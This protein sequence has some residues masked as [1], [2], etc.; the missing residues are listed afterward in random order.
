MADKGEDF[1]NDCEVCGEPDT[2]ICGHWSLEKPPRMPGSGIKASDLVT[3]EPIDP[4]DMVARRD[5][6]MKRLREAVGG[7]EPPGKCLACG[8]DPMNRDECFVCGAEQWEIFALR[9]RALVEQLVE[10]IRRVGDWESTRV[11]DA[12]AAYDGARK[13]EKVNSW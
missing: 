7:W 8:M 13:A 10:A 1:G 3:V 6:E 11:G 12:L 9:E 4:D 2:R 5:A